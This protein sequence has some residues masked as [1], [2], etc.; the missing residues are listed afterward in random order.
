MKYDSSKLYIIFYPPWCPCLCGVINMALSVF[1]VSRQEDMQIGRRQVKQRVMHTERLVNRMA[2]HKQTYVDICRCSHAPCC[3]HLYKYINLYL[4][5]ICG[6]SFY[7]MTFPARSHTLML[8][9]L[10]YNKKSYIP[11]GWVI[12]QTIIINSYNPTEL[13]PRGLTG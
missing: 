11:D 12:K 3:S 10:Y 8:Q 1:K 2:G 5:N 7:Y 13:L 9:I 4:W 6:I